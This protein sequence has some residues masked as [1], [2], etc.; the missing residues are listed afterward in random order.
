MIMLAETEWLELPASLRAEFP[1]P[2]ARNVVDGAVIAHVEAG[3][4]QPLLMLHGNPT[5][6]FLYRRIIMELRTDFR[7]IAPDYAGF[8]RSE[9][10]R[11]FGFTPFEH[12]Q[13]LERWLLEQ[14]LQD[15]LLMVQDWGGPIGF[16]LAARHPR[17]VAG[18]VIGNTWAWPVNGDLHFE[19]FSRLFGGAFGKWA[20]RRYNAFVE[21]LLPAGIRRRKVEK[22]VMDA[23]RLPFREPEQRIAT[24]VFP[25]EII[26]SRA[27]LSEV[28]A[29]LPALCHLDSLIVWGNRDPAFRKRERHR[30]E[31]IFPAARTVMLSGAGHFIQEDAPLEIA[32]AIREHW[33]R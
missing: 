7:C 3:S 2:V 8:G 10:P 18:L 28:E 12:A 33:P 13:L 15:I 21:V 30:F 32:D 29:A 17:R 23:Y 24:H 6:S 19:W 22:A 4:G 26:G 5:W 14:D 25:R 1:W 27:F 20:I 9:T 11:G 16:W 31:T